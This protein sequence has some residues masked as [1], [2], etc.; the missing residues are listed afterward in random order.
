MNNEESV[1][2]K[3]CIEE[4]ERQKNNLK[5]TLDDINNEIE[6]LKEVLDIINS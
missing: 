5:Y 3:N 1:K 4:L 6:V 2:L